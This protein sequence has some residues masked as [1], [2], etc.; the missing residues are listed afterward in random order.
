MART[1]VKC[2]SFIIKHSDTQHVWIA[3]NRDHAFKACMNVWCVCA[4]V[5]LYAWECV[6]VSRYREMCISSQVLLYFVPFST[7]PVTSQDETHYLICRQRVESIILTVLFVLVNFHC[8]RWIILINR[9]WCESK[10]V[11]V[12]RWKLSLILISFLDWKI[13]QNWSN[14][15]KETKL[16]KGKYHRKILDVV[17]FHFL[18]HCVLLIACR[19][20]MWL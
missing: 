12:W 18:V 10:E 1:I 8:Y 15:R 17:N 13:F 3:I 9:D 4:C 14:P 5:C 20:N 11:W 2:L 6:C 19:T 16:T 7:M